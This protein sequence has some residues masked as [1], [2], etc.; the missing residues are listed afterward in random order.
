[1]QLWKD[2]CGI[3]IEQRHLPH[4]MASDLVYGSVPQVL[5]CTED[6]MRLRVDFLL[7]QGLSQEDIGKA[8]SAHPHVS[9]G[10]SDRGVGCPVVCA[11]LC[12][13]WR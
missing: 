6:M 3:P 12:G 1:M 2:M 4:G 5:T 11:V 13:R 8:V 9:W 7:L 10:R